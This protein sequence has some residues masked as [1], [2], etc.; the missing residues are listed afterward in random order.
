[1]PSC[2][3]CVRYG[4][5]CSFLEL[6]LDKS[7]QFTDYSPPSLSD[8]ASTSCDELLRSGSSTSSADSPSSADTFSSNSL[9]S[10]DQ[11]DGSD[12]LSIASPT[13]AFN[14]TH[15]ERS[16]FNIFHTRVVSQLSGHFDGWFW[17][18]AVLQASHQEPI[19]RHA[20][21]ALSGL[22]QRVDLGDRLAPLAFDDASECI[23]AL[24]HYNHAIRKLR[25]S[26]QRRQLSLDVCL[27]TCLLFAYFEVSRRLCCPWPRRWR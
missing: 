24:Q 15:Q 21:L 7:S 23:F 26:A 6:A 19:I 9:T 17:H 27:I 12:S 11:S 5:S 3:K 18:T 16:A 1:M 10:I 8:R 25:F 13:F 4:S 20:I 2:Y 14:G 22:V